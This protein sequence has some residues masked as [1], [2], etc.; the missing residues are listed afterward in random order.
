MS[1]QIEVDN[2]TFG[3]SNYDDIKQAETVDTKNYTVVDADHL[4]EDDVIDE[5][6]YCLL[7]FMS[8]EGIMNCNTRAVK[9][10]GAFPTLEA[11]EKH[12]AKLE[13]QDGYFKIFVGETGKWLPCDPNTKKVD[14]E[15]T[16]NQC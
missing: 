1:N 6:R 11:A 5:Q 7:S 9:F 10:R 8:P 2:V 12:A 15:K 3:Q 13:K 4:D 16:S 14:Q